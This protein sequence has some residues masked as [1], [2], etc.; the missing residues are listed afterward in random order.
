MTSPLYAAGVGVD[1]RHL[2]PAIECENPDVTGA[3]QPEEPEE[4]WA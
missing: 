4:R 3:K 1:L 2:L